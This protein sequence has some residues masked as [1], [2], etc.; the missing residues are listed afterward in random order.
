MGETLCCAQFIATWITA[1][2]K[3]RPTALNSS[4]QENPGNASP[5][6]TTI[7][8]DNSDAVANCTTVT[9]R[10]STCPAKALIRM[11]SA[12]TATA[13]INVA[14]SPGLKFSEAPAGPVSSINPVN[15]SMM[16]MAGI[17]AGRRPSTNHCNRGTN[18]TYSAVMNADWLLGMVC[19]PMVCMP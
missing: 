10:T 6:G 18:G 19:N 16:P 14:I 2:V 11:I 8:N 1:L 13:Q 15:A 12:A 9:R 17:S 5:I 4:N 7:R 3:P